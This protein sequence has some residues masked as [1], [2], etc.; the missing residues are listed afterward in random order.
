MRPPKVYLYARCSTPDQIHGDS[1]RRQEAYC[2]QHGLT[3][4]DTL[5]YR[6]LGVSGYTGANVE[7][8]KLGAF[9]K[10]IKRGDVHPGDTLLVESLDRLTRAKPLTALRLIL[11]IVEAGVTLITI[12]DNKIYSGESIEEFETL[13]STLVKVTANHQDSSNKVRHLRSAWTTKRAN[14]GTQLMTTI[15]PA[16]IKVQDNKFVLIDERADIV[17]EIFRLTQNGLGKRLIT[18]QF[19]S[20]KVLFFGRGRGWRETYI[21]KILHNRSVLG[22]FNPHTKEKGGK[23]IPTD[24][25]LHDYYPRVISDDEFDIVQSQLKQ[26]I[27]GGGR[28]NRTQQNIFTNLLKC[29]YCGGSMRRERKDTLVLRCDKALRGM[30]CD[31]NRRYS[32][33]VVESTLLFHIHNLDIER[34]LNSSEVDDADLAL[35]KL[36]REIEVLKT[37]RD[38][39]QAAIELGLDIPKQVQRYKELDAEL[40]AKEQ[41]IHVPRAPKAEDVDMID[42]LIERMDEPEFRLAIRERIR[43]I[44]SSISFY[45]DHMEIRYTVGSDI[46]SIEYMV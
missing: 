18:K 3:V 4:D 32:Y 40:A 22:E 35:F 19:N 16:W 12:S 9:L 43:A 34:L 1:L 17:R 30:Q 39:V 36:R 44:V 38:G 26:R 23:R 31:H 13:I 46:D 7:T 5:T 24:I 11:S 33:L 20:S 37:A 21:S 45:L 8:G 42:Q 2:F 6:D 25:V 29:G 14:A 10:A 27:G 28:P 41:L 15:C